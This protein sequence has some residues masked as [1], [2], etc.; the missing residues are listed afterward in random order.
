LKNRKKSIPLGRYCLLALCFLVPHAAT[1]L[2]PGPQQ[3]SSAAAVPPPGYMAQA[4]E[5]IRQ[6][7]YLEARARLLPVVKEHPA[8]PRAQFFLGLT[9]QKEHRYAEAQP[10]FERVLK[11][12]PEYHEVRVFNGWCLYYMGRMDDA[13]AMFSSF[14]EWRPDYPDAHFALGLIEFDED[15]LVEARRRFEHVISLTDDGRSRRSEAKARARLADVWVRSGKLQAA[16]AELMRSIE[17][18]PSNYESYYKLSRVLDRLGRAEEA[19]QARQKHR[20][21]QRRVRPTGGGS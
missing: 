18:N 15:D 19:E 20:E 2:E 6:G 7:R 8:W 13:R 12:D 11:L 21:V 3:G 10:L 4:M 9:Y 16:H 14:L 17:L 1:A 5:L